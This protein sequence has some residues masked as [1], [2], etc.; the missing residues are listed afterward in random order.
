MELQKGTGFATFH[1][2]STVFGV[3]F[4]EYKNPLENFRSNLTGPSHAL[5]TTTS[6][7]KTTICTLK[8]RNI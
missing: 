1:E 2:K 7:S 8:I 3:K 4:F 5:K 6:I